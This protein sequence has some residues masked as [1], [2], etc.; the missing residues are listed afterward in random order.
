MYT[1]VFHNRLACFPSNQSQCAPPGLRRERKQTNPNRTKKDFKS[2][3][4][5]NCFVFILRCH[6][7][8]PISAE[9][10]VTWAM[11]LS[12]L[13]S[14]RVALRPLLSRFLSTPAGAVLDPS[15][16][17]S[18]QIKS[19]DGNLATTRMNLFTAVNE[20]MRVAMRSDPTAI[21]FGEDVAFGGVFRCSVGLLEEFGPER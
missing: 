8:H 9:A 17:A 19:N 6:Q 1:D 12:S 15:I 13:A 11:L 21:T 16:V 4:E 14:R 5:L 7:N 10:L 20:A 2:V 3:V 18:K